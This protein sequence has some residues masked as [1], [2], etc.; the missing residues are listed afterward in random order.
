MSQAHK[1]NRKYTGNKNSIYMLCHKY[2]LVQTITYV[3]FPVDN[4]T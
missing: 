2:K 1:L 4:L 3:I